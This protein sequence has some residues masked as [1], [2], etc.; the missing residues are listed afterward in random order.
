MAG[1]ARRAVPLACILLGA[2]LAGCHFGGHS[3]SVKPGSEKAAAAKLIVTR[4]PDSLAPKG[5]PAH[6]L[7][8]EPWIY[9]HWLPYD[10]G[11]L[12][13]VL[14]ITRDDLWG[15]LRDDHRTLAEL[16]ARHGWRDPKALAAKLVGTRD[17][18]PA[19]RA[20]LEARAERTI[21]QGHL[22]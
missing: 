3:A 21:T 14:H 2:G 18:G 11:R 12:Y 15:Q 17:V 22:A 16:A 10:E 9:N 6:W 8:P 1:A 13:R 5:A 19:T 4:S 20:V 7:P